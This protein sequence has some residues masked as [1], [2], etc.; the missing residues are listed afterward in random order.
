MNINEQ[1]HELGNTGGLA[2]TP[3][4]D[5]IASLLTKTKRVRAAR[6]S[7][8]TLIGTVGA[9]A[10]GIAAAQAYT[11]AKE[12]PAFR[13]RNVINNKN[14]L[15]PIELY[16]A[17]FGDDNPTRAFDSGVDLSSIIAKLKAA[18]A[19][20]SSYPNGRSGQQAAPPP[21]VQKPATPS[22]TAPST[23]APSTTAAADPYAPCKADHPEKP[24]K[25]YNCST[26]RWVIKTG[27]YQDLEDSSYYQCAAQPAYV[28]YTY[29]CGSGKYVAKDGYF[30]FG[31]GSVYRTITWID[32][33]TGVS[34]TG[35]WSGSGNWGGWDL[36]AIQ[37]DPGSRSYSEY[38]YMGGN[39]SWSGSTCTGVSAPM[40]GASWHASCLPESKVSATGMTYKMSNGLAWVLD[41][42]DL[43]WHPCL[44][45]YADPANPPNGWMWDGGGWVETPE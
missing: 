36:K 15:T 12:D 34:S 40:Y 44:N 4:D 2:Y 39:A 22:K 8:T 31:N 5:V 26:S 25:Y 33:A 17:K 30:W 13:D 7:A 19:S 32:S 38:V 18:A 1:L 11:T 43:R 27:W 14:G 24:Y 10:I 42:Q 16:R 41:N 28:G 6:Q 37:S 9:L 23:T 20:G 45:S 3:N 21:V 35:N 29:D